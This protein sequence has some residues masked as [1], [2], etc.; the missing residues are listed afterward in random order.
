METKY[1][2]IQNITWKS[3][4]TAEQA[5]PPFELKFPVPATWQYAYPWQR[6]C[7]RIPN[8]ESFSFIHSPWNNIIDNDVEGALP[9]SVQRFQFHLIAKR[10]SA[11]FR[12]YRIKTQRK[13]F[14]TLFL[15]EIPL[16]KTKETHFIMIQSIY[17]IIYILIFVCTWPGWLHLLADYSLILIWLCRAVF[18]LLLTFSLLFCWLCSLP[19]IHMTHKWPQT[20]SPARFGSAQSPPSE[21]VRSGSSLALLLKS[22]LDFPGSGWKAA[23]V[24]IALDYPPG[25]N[26]WLMVVK[27]R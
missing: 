6:N 25:R 20:Y 18:G 23:H 9:I 21:W 22:E 1:I 17:Y 3:K 27:E 5:N 14:K 8:D 19:F 2:Y 16:K 12:G 15:I 26:R 11:T 13:I 24:R 10:N 4:S 7:L